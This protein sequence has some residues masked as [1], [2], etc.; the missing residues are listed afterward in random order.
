MDKWNKR[1]L[2]FT[3]GLLGGMVCGGTI[4][5]LIGLG[6]QVIKNWLESIL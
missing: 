6:Y 4:I 5:E 1:I 3:I 2:Y